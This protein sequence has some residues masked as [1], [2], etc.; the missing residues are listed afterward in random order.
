MGHLKMETDCDLSIVSTSTQE[1][2]W[3]IAVSM[4]IQLSGWRTSASKRAFPGICLGLLNTL[5]E[6]GNGVNRPGF[7]FF[8]C[9]V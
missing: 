2:I 8:T 9:N 4:S 6:G 5:I 1:I 3:E 7:D